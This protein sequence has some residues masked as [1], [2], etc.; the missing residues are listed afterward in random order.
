[1]IVAEADHDVGFGA[2]VGGDDPDDGGHRL[3]VEQQKQAGG[4][5]AEGNG[6]VEEQPADEVDSDGLGELF[7]TAEVMGGH[8][9]ALG[10]PAVHS[11]TM[12][13]CTCHR[14]VGGASATRRGQ[15][16][17]VRRDR[18]PGLPA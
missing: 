14:V 5:H 7:P 17:G 9:D 18:D 4:A 8:S 2:H 1:M 12:K 15:L 10:Q 16:A 3:G 13:A 6:I 11:H